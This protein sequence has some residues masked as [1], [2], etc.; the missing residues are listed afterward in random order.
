[1]RTHHHFPGRQTHTSR[2]TV[3]SPRDVFDLLF[4]SQFEIVRFHAL[5]ESSQ[6]LV[7]ES[8]QVF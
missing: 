4:G 5:S 7:F 1:M 3:M 6:A 8:Q 2:K